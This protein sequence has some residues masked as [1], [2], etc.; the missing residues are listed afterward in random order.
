MKG[1]APNFG[2]WLDC[3]FASDS[4]QAAVRRFQSWDTTPVAFHLTYKHTLEHP[5]DGEWRR[6]F[7]CFSQFSSLISELQFTNLAGRLAVR[8]HASYF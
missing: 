2:S 8:L 7:K 5:I 4:L 3:G 6:I 1:R